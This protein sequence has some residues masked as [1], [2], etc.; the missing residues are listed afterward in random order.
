MIRLMAAAH[1]ILRRKRLYEGTGFPQAG[2]GKPGENYG[3][4]RSCVIYLFSVIYNVS[5]W[6]N[7]VLGVWLLPQNVPFVPSLFGTTS[8]QMVQVRMEWTRRPGSSI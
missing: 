1:Y 7:G 5:G 8:C 2:Q 3:E 6:H 4:S